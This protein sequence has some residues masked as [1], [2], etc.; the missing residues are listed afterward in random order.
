MQVPAVSLV[1]SSRPEN[2]GSC[3]FLLVLI[4]QSAGCPHIT[5]GHHPVPRRRD[6]RLPCSKRAV[7]I[8]ILWCTLN[9]LISAMVG[10]H[11]GNFW[12]GEPG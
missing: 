6:H 5:R 3:T 8:L 4:R 9:A 2:T 12:G 11:G 7:S 10:L 1:H